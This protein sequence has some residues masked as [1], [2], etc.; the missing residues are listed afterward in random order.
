VTGGLRIF[1][2]ARPDD[3]LLE[4]G[5]VTARRWSDWLRV[6]FRVVSHAPKKSPMIKMTHGRKFSVRLDRP[7]PF[8][9]DG[10]ARTTT[11]KLR[12][13]VVPDAICVCVPERARSHRAQSDLPAR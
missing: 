11:R 13:Q 9:L 6:L 3:G 10:G 2:D 7:M 4:V 12:A 1:P 8:E 5:V